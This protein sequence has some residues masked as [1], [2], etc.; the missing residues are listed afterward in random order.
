MPTEATPDAELN[1]IITCGHRTRQ[2]VQRLG[3]PD[4]NNSGPSEAYN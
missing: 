2:R 4:T 1:G 3:K